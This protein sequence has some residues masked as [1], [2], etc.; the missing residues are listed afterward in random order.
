MLRFDGR[1][2]DVSGFEFENTDQDGDGPE[3]LQSFLDACLGREFFPGANAEVGLKAVATLDA[4]Y[5]SA[6]SGKAEPT[7]L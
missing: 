2:E 4:M 1:Q 6:L 5:R 3:S 7:H